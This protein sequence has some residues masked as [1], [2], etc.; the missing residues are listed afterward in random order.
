M[1]RVVLELEGYAFESAPDAS[2]AM[3]MAG[4]H[5]YDLFLLDHGL[6]GPVTGM[7]LCQWLRQRDPETPIILASAHA[8]PEDRVAA[9]RAGASA[10]LVKPVAPPHLV[11]T[12][13]HVLAQAQ[14]Q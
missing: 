6:G 9:A 8:Y 1:Y 4:T 5:H 10:Y 2:T 7:D 11:E 3:A 14:G 12:V 13:G